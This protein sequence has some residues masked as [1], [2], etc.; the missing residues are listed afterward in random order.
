MKFNTDPEFI[1]LDALK[2]T[3]NKQVLEFEDWA[4]RN[5]WEKFHCSHY[6]WWTFP[7][8]HR[9]SYGS[10]YV[11][12][13][14]E[15]TELKKD[16]TFL[17]GYVKGAKLV[18]ASWGWDLKYCEKLKNH[19]P[20]QSWHQWPVRLYKA[21]LSVKL[22]GYDE[23]FFSLQTFALDLISKGEGFVFNGRDLSSLFRTM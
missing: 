4:T 11:V 12:F 20:G 19:L 10:K 15:I 13:E 14:G 3:H 21:A 22:F 9:S 7:I 1:G 16:E 6:D 8:N 18:S 5:D 23:L 17:E 2:Q